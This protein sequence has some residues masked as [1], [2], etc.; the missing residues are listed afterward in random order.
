MKI[1]EVEAGSSFYKKSKIDLKELLEDIFEMFQPVAEDR[2]V[3]LNI[4]AVSCTVAVDPG[5][6]V[7]ALINLL[8]NAL[9]GYSFAESKLI[10]SLSMSCEK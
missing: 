3:Q 6:I 5:L 1:N 9:N 7:Q 4:E 8:E 2:K 10:N